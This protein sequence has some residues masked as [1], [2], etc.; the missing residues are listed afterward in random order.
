MMVR[1]FAAVLALVCFWASIAEAQ[2]RV[3]GYTRRDGTYV[4]PH[5]RSSPNSTTSDNYSTRGNVNPYT[6]ELGTRNPTTSN[7]PYVYSPYPTYYVPH[8][9]SSSGFSAGNE[10]TRERTE[11]VFSGSEGSIGATSPTQEAPSPPSI[12]TGSD[13]YDHCRPD[14]SEADL[15]TCLGYLNGINDATVAWE[16]AGVITKPFC[17]PDSM[18]IGE[19]ATYTAD[20]I[21]RDRAQW[22]SHSGLAVM[23]VWLTGYPCTTGE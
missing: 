17:F 11:P 8:P 2:V 20:A 6:G 23:S 7:R 5:Y 16:D 12:L 14:A 13:V 15:L 10:T 18:T 1:V 4:A 9:P 21:R 19:L 22:E 3:R